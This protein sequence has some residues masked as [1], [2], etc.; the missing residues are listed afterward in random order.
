MANRNPY[1]L[2]KKEGRMYTFERIYMEAARM[3]G[4]GMYAEIQNRK[5]LGYKKQRAARELNVD[6]KTVR[7]YWDMAEEEYITQQYESKERRKNMDPYR[8]YVL[9]KLREHSEITSAIIYDNLREEFADFEPSYRSVRRY[10]LMLRETEGLPAPVKI[11]QYMEVTELPPGF[12]AQVDMGQKTMKD[13]NGKRVKV[14]AARHR[15]PHT[16]KTVGQSILP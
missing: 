9:D 11:R 16:Q 3:V 14:L 7:K 15:P 12:Q 8:E 4:I 13:A 5:K 6:T 10:V 2:D 1:Y